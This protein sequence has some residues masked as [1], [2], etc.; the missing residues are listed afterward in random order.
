MWFDG[1]AHILQVTWQLITQ[2]YASSG[3]ARLV[4]TNCGQ[5]IPAGPRP[6]ALGEEQFKGTGLVL[7]GSLRRTGWPRISGW[8]KYRAILPTKKRGP[9]FWPPCKSEISPG[10]GTK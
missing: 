3:V 6:A 7:V 1:G 8:V 9:K 2:D 4:S 5:E 10:I